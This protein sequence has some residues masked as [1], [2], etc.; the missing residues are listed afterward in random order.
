ASGAGPGAP[1][2]AATGVAAASAEESGEASDAAG[3]AL[4]GSPGSGRGPPIFLADW[5]S[6]R[7]TACLTRSRRVGSEDAGGCGTG[8]GPE[9]GFGSATCSLF[10]SRKEPQ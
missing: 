8:A 4:P 3:D 5:G 7:P 1:W 9:T 10:H 6:S 2:P